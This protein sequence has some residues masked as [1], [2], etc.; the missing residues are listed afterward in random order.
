M[1]TVAKRLVMFG[2]CHGWIAAGAVE[3]AFRVMRLQGA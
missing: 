3:V 1:R 2:Y